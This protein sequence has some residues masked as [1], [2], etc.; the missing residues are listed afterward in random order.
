MPFK[1]ILIHQIDFPCS[2]DQ[3]VAENSELLCFIDN[4]VSWIEVS[5]FYISFFSFVV[6]F[7]SCTF[8]V[9]MV[10]CLALFCFYATQKLNA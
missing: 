2:V 7:D 8:V 3:Q 5:T 10:P 4:L 6:G 1:F 9:T